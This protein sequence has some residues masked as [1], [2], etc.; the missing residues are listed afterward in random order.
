M[1]EATLRDDVGRIG[2][3]AEAVRW[4]AARVPPAAFVNAVAQDE[5]THD[6]VVRVG[7]RAYVVFDTT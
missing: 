4:A 2:S 1:N 5:F 3:I 7:R 6:V